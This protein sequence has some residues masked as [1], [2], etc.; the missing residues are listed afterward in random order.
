MHCTAHSQALGREGAKRAERA[1]P[2]RRFP[3]WE[4][5]MIRYLSLAALLAVGATIGYAQGAGGAAAIDA[6]KAA[7][8]AVGGANKGLT[9]MAKGDVAFDAAKAAAGF[10]TIEENLVKSKPLYGDDSKTGDT[11]ALPAVWEKKAD[12]QAKF[13]KA[14]ADAKT[15]GSASATEAAFKDQHK[16]MVSNC[17]GCHKDYRQ[18]PKK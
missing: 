17:G 8:K 2:Q 7:M 14:I 3:L 9:D 5:C 12:F 4:T 10:K 13:D 16:A 15:A 11:A 18:P 1:S 6:R